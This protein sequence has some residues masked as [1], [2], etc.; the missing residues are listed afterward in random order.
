MEIGG[1]GCGDVRSGVVVCGMGIGE[2]EGLGTVGRRGGIEE[3]WGCIP[4]IELSNV[5]L[6]LKLMCC[7]G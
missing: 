6:G 7:C 1:L 5:F 4:I 2:S 3:V